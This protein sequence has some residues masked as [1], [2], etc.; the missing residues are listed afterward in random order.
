M[1][2]RRIWLFVCLLA[3]ALPLFAH[4]PEVMLVRV[5]L[6]KNRAYVP[7]G[8][9]LP[10]GLEVRA[11]AISLPQRTAPIELR[12][13][14]ERSFLVKAHADLLSRRSPL[15]FE[16]APAETFAGT[17]ER[18]EQFKAHQAASSGPSAQSHYGGCGTTYYDV[19]NTGYY[20]DTYYSWFA[21]KQCIAYQGYY[22][23]WYT[24]GTTA[25]AEDDGYVW[26]YDDTNA[27][28]CDDN[29]PGYRERSCETEN[30]RSY[31]ASSTNKVHHGGQSYHIEYLQNY[32]PWYVGFSLN[33]QYTVPH[34]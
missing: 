16:Y 15:V 21:T 7:E 11:A 4:E 31:N 27:F 18:Y 23:A 24:Y 12:H 33:V 19:Q 26:V 13:G 25:A 28:T 29:Y 1:T 2:G 8:T 17:R 6:E 32:E 30:Y 20:N 14:G 5:D 34:Y 9:V 22:A 3:I 10:P